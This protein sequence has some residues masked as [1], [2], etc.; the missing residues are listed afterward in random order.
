MRTRLLVAAAFVAAPFLRAQSAS[1]H[2][3]G[4]DDFT[5]LRDAHAVAVAPDGKRILYEIGYFET[6]GHEKHEWHEIGVG[7]DNDRTVTLP[8]HFTPSGYT[9]DG[10]SLYGSDEVDGSAQLAI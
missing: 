5:G 4:L 10:A 6:T 1:V 2:P 9:P 3:F 7:G 8:P